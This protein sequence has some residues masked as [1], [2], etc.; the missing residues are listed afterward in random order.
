MISNNESLYS[1]ILRTYHGDD[2]RKRK[3]TV[4]FATISKTINE[5]VI[6][7]ESWNA[8][9][10][11][12]NIKKFRT[13][14]ALLS[15]TECINLIFRLLAYLYIKPFLRFS[16]FVFLF[17]IRFYHS[18]HPEVISA[19]MNESFL[20]RSIWT[21]YYINPGFIKPANTMHINT[22]QDSHTSYST[23]PIDNIIA[24][25]TIIARTA[26]ADMPNSVVGIN[27]Q[28][29]NSKKQVIFTNYNSSKKL[30]RPITSLNNTMMLVDFTTPL[31]ASIPLSPSQK[32]RTPDSANKKLSTKQTKPRINKKKN[33]KQKHPQ[34]QKRSRAFGYLIVDKKLAVIYENGNA[35]IYKVSQEFINKYI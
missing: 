17:L 5:L 14:F 13:T 35:Y 18:A 28:L 34:P 11:R 6:L 1:Y 30:L 23:K 27:L 24:K 22:H 33:Q 15:D 26:R 12:I 32:T 31:A 25:R 19:R 3:K 8:T 21:N 9:S 16:L 29:S 4:L 7:P 10:A 2:I 20:I